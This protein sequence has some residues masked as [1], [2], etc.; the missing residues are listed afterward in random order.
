MCVCVR[1]AI[2]TDAEPEQKS[3]I[4]LIVMMALLDLLGGWCVS[5]SAVFMF[6]KIFQALA[7][8]SSQ[9]KKRNRIIVCCSLVC[10]VCRAAANLST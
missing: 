8:Q 4:S 3:R 5:V 7:A 6:W 2:T 9:H 1:V 10:L